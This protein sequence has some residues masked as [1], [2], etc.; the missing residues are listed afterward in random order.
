MIADGFN[1]AADLHILIGIVIDGQPLPQD[2]DLAG[3]SLQNHGLL[4]I[5]QYPP[6]VFYKGIQ[7]MH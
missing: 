7:S 2:T 4:R 3:L 5:L 1:A 6:V